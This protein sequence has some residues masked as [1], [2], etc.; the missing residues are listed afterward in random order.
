MSSQPNRF[1]EFGRFRVDVAERRLLRDGEPVLL[2]PKAFET[3]LAL[4]EHSG[5]LLQKEELMRTVW[6]D[7]F[8]EENNLTQHIYVL[9][10]VLGESN[11]QKYIETVPRLGYR[12]T[13]GVREVL[14]EGADLFV[15]NRT[16]Y[17]V[18]VKEESYE[19][20]HE[21]DEA[22]TVEPRALPTSLTAPRP[23]LKPT[24]IIL[25]V[26]FV[27]VGL[28]VALIWTTGKTRRAERGSGTELAFNSIAV[29]P[30]KTIGEEDEHLG[31]GM[32]D[33]L[34][35]KLSRVRRISVRPISAV[36]RFTGLGQDPVA[37]GRA[38]GVDAVLD[39]RVQRAGGR[40]RVTIEL[41]SVREGAVLWTETLDENFTDVFTLQDIIAARVVRSLPAPVT[42]EEKALLAK[43]HTINAEAYDA[44][45]KG[46]YFWNKRTQVGFAKAVEYFR[47]AIRLDPGYAA[48]YAG[49]AD[50]YVL[51][52]DP[53]PVKEHTRRLKE[54]AGRALE[55]DDTLAEA[56]ASL[57]YYIG[58]IEWDWPGAEKGFQRAIE[59]NPGYATARHWYAYHL[60]AMGKLE[61]ALAEIRRAQELDPLSLI[62]KTDIGH[63]LYLAR[64]FDEAIAQYRQVL[65][66][67]ANFAVAH[68]RLG[69]AYT[70]KRM[71]RE[72]IAEFNEAKK[73]GVPTPVGWLGYAQAT[74]GQ[75]G[76]AQRSIAEL[77]KLAPRQGG[78]YWYQI[79]VVY[80][81]LGD[82]E[83]A[84][85]W[86][87][88]TYEAHDAGEM[89]LIK[90]DP[91]LEDLRS[92][93]DFINL[94]RRMN[95]AP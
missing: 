95:L 15:E 17:R 28:A 81:G 20:E 44:Y 76:E 85:A 47:D 21:T 67:D 37:A 45:L 54:T 6:P 79:A 88:K 65:E 23:R 5:H 80:T 62:I 33:T 36:H 51:G 9:R 38:L 43:R 66:M 31:L 72:A 56:H 12:F 30:F 89:A 7:A 52:A 59:L 27:L 58:A 86:L 78:S 63:I 70:E 1:F 87:E 84:L 42:R 3:L 61:G 4:V 68:W 39:G 22:R 8:V 16:K 73:L 64:Q 93:P 49:L 77:K 19:E 55:L 90:V 50:C 14:D 71:Y 24:H 11:G 82:H 53:L 83:Q 48:A 69:E 40:I 94:L 32:A 74:A 34:I 29:L 91:R 41:V 26:S 57:A 92:E 10:K 35:A 2:P 60:A 75:K 25:A 18:I 13:A 46:R